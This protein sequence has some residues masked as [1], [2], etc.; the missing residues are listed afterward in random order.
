MK[1]ADYTFTYS[2][3]FAAAIIAPLFIVKLP[4]RKRSV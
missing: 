1:N 2:E 3:C 4:F